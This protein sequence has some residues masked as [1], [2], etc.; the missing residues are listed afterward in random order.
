MELRTPKLPH[1]QLT[2][3]KRLTDLLDYELRAEATILPNRTFAAHY[4]V[5]TCSKNFG[6]KFH[7]PDFLKKISFFLTK[8]I[9]PNFP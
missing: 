1:L 5:T 2:A 8:L 7:I 9:F 6:I 3:F 4:E